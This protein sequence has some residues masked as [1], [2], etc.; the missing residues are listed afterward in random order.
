MVQAGRGG[1]FWRSV[2]DLPGRMPLRVKLIT[3]LLVLVAIALAVI[4]LVGIALLQDNLLGPPDDQL[5]GLTLP[6][7]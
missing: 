2:R 5:Q 3:A 7:Q 6:E 4:S 1:G